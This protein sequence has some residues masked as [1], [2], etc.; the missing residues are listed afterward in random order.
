[1]KKC[2]YILVI[3]LL[4]LYSCKKKDITEESRLF[5]PIV[6]GQLMADSNTIIATW[7][8]MNAAKSYMV[9]VS[10][11]TFRTIDR[12]V[13]L[14]TNVAQIKGLL[15]N[16][17]YQVQVKAIAAD[18]V[19]NSLWSNLGAVKTLTS[20]LKVPLVTD[21]TLNSVRVSWTSKGA[22][23]TSVKIIKTS[24]S[25]TVS[26]TTLTPL[27]VLNESVIIG[28]LAS[29]TKYTIFLNSGTDVRGYADFTTKAPFVGSVIDL[30]GI[31]GRPSVLADTL[32]LIPAGSTVLLKRGETYNISSAINL[33]KSVIILSAPDLAVTTQAKIFFTSNFNFAA[34][35]V[36]DSLEF[37]DV[38]MY[39]DN[40]GS[41]YAFNTTNSATVGKIKF[42]NSRV[43]IFRGILRLQSGTTSVGSLIIDNSIIDSVSNYGVLTIGSATTKVDNISITN[44]TIYKAEVVI[45]SASSSN[46]ILIDAC[47][48]HEAPAGN[49]ATYYINYGTTLNVTNGITV[50]NCIF[51]YGKLS[52]GAVTV[53]D[54]RASATTI[55]SATN[56]FR[57]SDHLTAGNDFPNI[58]T[59]NRPAAQLWLDP[60]NGNFKIND[61]TF[62][63]RFTTGDPRWR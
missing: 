1:M 33:S 61:I 9:Q 5:R 47:T 31:I 19:L 36:I 13:K 8:K 58:S 14:D 51:G 25:S 52:A 46:S 28:G 57:T 42:V 44:S 16:Q 53:R 43:E 3:G 48:F 41:R 55:M 11:D 38:F 7:Q 39:S 35:A 22:P 50:T 15:Y 63:G 18:T 27:N 2:F 29:A 21:I 23:V 17:L 49:S 4:F 24:D 32:G 20:I 37:N 56:N 60:A 62:P 59:Y 26:Q 40:Y 12:S 54:Y 45:T 34:G 10:R 6:V 30:T